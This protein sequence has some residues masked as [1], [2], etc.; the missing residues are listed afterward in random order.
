MA[1][2]SR[3]KV[4]SGENEQAEYLKAKITDTEKLV[5]ALRLGISDITEKLKQQME[6]MGASPLSASR[7]RLSAPLAS[8]LSPLA[9][10]LSPLASRL[11]PLARGADASQCH[12][13]SGPEV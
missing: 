7:A 4:G 2:K 11:S 9:S 6:A 1:S 13:Q 5:E 8:R 3:R 12:R 10:R